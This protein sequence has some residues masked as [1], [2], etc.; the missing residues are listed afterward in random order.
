MTYHCGLSFPGERREPHIT[1]DVC[2]T[3]HRVAN[4]AGVPYAWFLDEKAPRGWKRVPQGDGPAAHYC[5]RCRD[6][7]WP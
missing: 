5:G 1:C 2:G 4:G 7:G 3:V 6:E